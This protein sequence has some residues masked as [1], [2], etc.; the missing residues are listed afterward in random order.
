MVPK[1]DKYRA[2]RAVEE[3]VAALG[4]AGE[5]LELHVTQGAQGLA[6]SAG[7]ENLQRLLIDVDTAKTNH[8][9]GRTLETLIAALFKTVPEFSVQTKYS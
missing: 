6:D 3:M 5:I 1:N 4:N 7:T 8:E 2:N 9:K